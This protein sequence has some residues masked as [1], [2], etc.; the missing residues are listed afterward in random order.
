MWSE[1]S[2]GYYTRQKGSNTYRSF[3]DYICGPKKH[4]LMMY[5]QM[6]WLAFNIFIMVYLYKLFRNKSSKKDLLLAITLLGALVFY[7]IWEVKI[8]YALP[9]VP[10]IIAMA[11]M[12]GISIENKFTVPEVSTK[13]CYKVS[14]I[15]VATLFIA[16][17]LSNIYY[18]S[19]NQIV[20]ETPKIE[21]FSSVSNEIDNVS[22]HNKVLKQTFYADSDFNKLSFFS[23]D[24]HD[25]PSSK[26]KIR[27][28][29]S[30][31]KVLAEKTYSS[32]YTFEKTR[33]VI[34]KL[35]KTY[36]PTHNEKFTLTIKGLGAD[37]DYQQ[38]NYSDSSQINCLPGELKINGKPING[39]LKFGLFYTERTA[40]MSLPAYL[41]LIAIIALA[42][43]LVYI[44]LFKKK[45]YNLTKR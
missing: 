27:L 43:V 38:F 10:I 15:T 40:L 35:P 30:K 37:S 2:V 3:N 25:N 13:K 28:K 17:L 39:D 5:C 33:N 1:G 6:L 16:L 29:N 18:V 11:S 44:S 41:T 20:R 26:Y 12:G 9:F 14:Y 45:N 21:N 24:H 36:S 32:Y 23:I 4:M 19:F 8:N 34:L 22:E 42:E 31:N 7:M